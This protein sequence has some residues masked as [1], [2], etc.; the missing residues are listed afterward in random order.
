MSPVKSM[1]SVITAPLSFLILVM[2]GF[3]SLVSLQVYHFINL[4][5]KTSFLFWF[6][7]IIFVF[8]ILLTSLMFTAFFWLL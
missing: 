7:Y 6:S 5:K 3:F 8:S 1:R 2:Y 4:I